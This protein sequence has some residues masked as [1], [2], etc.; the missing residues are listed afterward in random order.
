[1]YHSFLIHSSADGHLG[2]FLWVP[3]SWVTV[4]HNHNHNSL[5]GLGD[6]QASVHVS[7]SYLEGVNIV[8]THPYLS[9]RTSSMML[10]LLSIP[11]I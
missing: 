1:M 5:F 4:D 2:C 11:K 7:G 10:L 6:Y 8:L 3:C 9:L